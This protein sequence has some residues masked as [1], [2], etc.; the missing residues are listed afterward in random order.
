M[1]KLSPI[2]PLRLKQILNSLGFFMIRQ[3][4]SHQ[5]F[6]HPDGRQTVIPIHSNEDIGKGLLKSILN[7]ID[8]S[9]KEFEVLRRKIK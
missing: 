4:G 1:T 3:K 5:V 9:S 8:L 6:R 7:D 2:S